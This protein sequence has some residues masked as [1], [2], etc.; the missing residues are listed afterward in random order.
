MKVHRNKFFDLINL[1]IENYDYSKQK[2]K[3]KYLIIFN[4]TQVVGISRIIF[5]NKE[6]FL[7]MVHTSIK[8]RGRGFCQFNITKIIELS[9][10]KHKIK[11]FKLDVDSDNYPAIKAY[12]KCGFNKTKKIKGKFGESYI[13]IKNIKSQ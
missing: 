10:K 13:M 1:V 8:F 11:T 3:V 5:Y 9:S 2:K 6:G 12:Q 7:N 4:K